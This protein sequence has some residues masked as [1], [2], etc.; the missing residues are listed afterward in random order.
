MKN[1]ICLAANKKRWQFWWQQKTIL[2][3]K[4]HFLVTTKNTKIN[5]AMFWPFLAPVSVCWHVV[6]FVLFGVFSTNKSLT[7]WTSGG[8]QF[9][10]YFASLKQPKFS[11]TWKTTKNEVKKQKMFTLNIFCFSFSPNLSPSRNH[12]QCTQ[13]HIPFITCLFLRFKPQLRV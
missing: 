4:Y 10:T 11:K 6:V 13:N 7:F 9:P 8:T 12:N 5:S 1:K 2:F 3:Q